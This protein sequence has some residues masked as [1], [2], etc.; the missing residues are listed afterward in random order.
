MAEDA[1]CESPAA[2]P[3]SGVLCLPKRLP[4]GAV[5]CG[6]CGREKQTRKVLRP[7]GPARNPVAASKHRVHSEL[8]SRRKL[9]PNLRQFHNTCYRGE[10]RG[11]RVDT[12]FKR[13][14][15][16]GNEICGSSSISDFVASFGSWEGDPGGTQSPREGHTAARGIGPRL[17]VSKN[18]AL[19]H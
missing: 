13:P 4:P 3:A 17:R 5:R 11:L 19:L 14:L 7:M 10:H 9:L 12:C 1:R 2:G 16:Y 8:Q 15:Y 18:Q 6:H